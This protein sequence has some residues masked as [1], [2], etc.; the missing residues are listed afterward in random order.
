MKG[1]LD[2]ERSIQNYQI[3]AKHRETMTCFFKAKNFEL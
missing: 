1:Q 3:K 2:K